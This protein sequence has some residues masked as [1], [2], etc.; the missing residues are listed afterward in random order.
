M[1]LTIFLLNMYVLFA[2]LLGSLLAIQFNDLNKKLDDST[3]H[4]IYRLLRIFISCFSFILLF[5]FCSSFMPNILNP[6]FFL[7][8]ALLAGSTA[9]I[10]SLKNKFLIYDIDFPYDNVFS[11][12][13]FLGNCIGCIAT[14]Y[15]FI[16][17]NQ[18]VIWAISLIITS[19]I[20]LVSA[21]IY[22][23][24]NFKIQKKYETFHF[25]LNKIVYANIFLMF[26]LLH[27]FYKFYLNFTQPETYLFFISP[28]YLIIVSLLFFYRGH[29]FLIN[30]YL[31]TQR[32]N[33]ED[34]NQFKFTDREKE[35]AKLVVKGYSNK[36]IASE[37]NISTPTV[38]SHIKHI[39]QKMDI[40]SR[41]EMI[42]LF[43]QGF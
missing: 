27:D 17:E 21:I 20:M 14:G 18:L 23:Q 41:F 40:N 6:K 43:I 31:K 8:F 15:Y 34:L 2:I 1:D 24:I 38:K 42:S 9:N 11:W 13:L 33:V 30:H 19:Y 36:A 25:F 5:I 4:Y 7:L 29:L 26:F 3:F 39:F 22:I 32:L 35:I 16:V 37:C 28:I 10:V 12:S